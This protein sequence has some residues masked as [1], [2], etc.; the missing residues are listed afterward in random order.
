MEIVN[1]VADDIY[2]IRLP[3]PFALS[4][5]N[6]YLLRDGNG[7]TV[8]DAGLNYQPGREAWQQALAVLGISWYSIQRI[9]LTH[10]HPDHYGAAGWL[11]EQSGAPVFASTVEQRFAEIVWRGGNQNDYRMVATFKLHG[12]P[13]D[14][15]PQ[16][17]DDMAALRQKTAPHPS[18]HTLD[19]GSIQ[20]GNRQFVA[21]CTPGHSD[22]HMVLHCADERLMLCGDT[23]L[24][25]ITPNIGI[26]P[27]S[28]PNP[29]A[30]FLHS[31]G[32]LAQ[33]NVECAL[34]GHG[35]VIMTFAQRIAELQAHHEERLQRAETIAGTGATAWQICSSLFAVAELSSHQLRFAM[36]ETLAHLEYLVHTGRVERLE[37]DGICYRVKV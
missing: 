28:R 17:L 6:S 27:T 31:L 13:A 12:V 30:D 26:W 24:M 16:V 29:L 2:Q 11:A 18:L 1:Q 15:A 35:P 23:V 3:L 7:W 36:A 8:I 19:P 22:G 34:P 5:M 20:I 25:R 32:R 33:C 14:L 10:T 37:G 21:F 9:I 4:S